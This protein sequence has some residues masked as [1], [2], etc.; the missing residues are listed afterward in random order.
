MIKIMILFYF[1][2]SL[3]MAQNLKTWSTEEEGIKLTTTYP[4]VL[5]YDKNL[6]GL[7]NVWTTPFVNGKGRSSLSLTVTGANSN[8]WDSNQLKKTESTYQEGRKNWATERG[9]EVTGFLPFSSTKNKNG[10]PM[11]TIGFSYKING[12]EQHE[13]SVYLEVKS[14][15]VHAKFVGPKSLDHWKVMKSIIDDLR[16]IP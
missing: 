7:P 10:L 14:K 2:T 3:L 15:L 1:M 16:T 8:G 6:L 4:E 5:K 9:Y 11:H 12:I 13:V